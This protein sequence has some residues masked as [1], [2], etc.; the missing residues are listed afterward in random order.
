MLIVVLG[1]T[2]CG[3]VKGACDGVELGNL[4]QTLSNIFR[5]VYATTTSGERSSKNEAFVEPAA[6]KNVELTVQNILDRSAVLREL[7]DAG[8]LQVVGAI[9]D[10]TTGKV[11]FLRVRVPALSSARSRAGD[12]A[13]AAASRSVRTYGSRA[14]V[15]D[16]RVIVAVAAG[17][18]PGAERDL[19]PAIFLRVGVEQRHQRIEPVLP[20][21]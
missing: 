20:A 12:S 8:K 21:A 14:K 2:S 6:R 10:V 19:F 7:V 3:A 4:T 13:G 16:S 5:A 1:H 9:H 17:F 11:D 15:A 18:D